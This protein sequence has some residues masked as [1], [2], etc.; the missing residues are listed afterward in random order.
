MTADAERLSG[1]GLEPIGR[2]RNH[3]IHRHLLDDLAVDAV[4]LHQPAV[5]YPVAN[6]DAADPLLPGRTRISRR[7]QPQRPATNG[8]NALAVHGPPHQ[9][10]GMQGFA[11]G[12]AARQPRAGA[13]ARTVGAVAAGTDGTG[14]DGAS[15]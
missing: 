5:M 8:R 4:F 11:D 14:L 10:A 3:A 9:R 12:Q 13:V 1:P 15:W 6:L 2:P 7:H